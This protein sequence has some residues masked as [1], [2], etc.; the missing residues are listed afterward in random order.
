VDIENYK[1]WVSENYLDTSIE[2]LGFHPN[3]NIQVNISEMDILCNNLLT[4]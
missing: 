4:V 1:E 3:A 2:L